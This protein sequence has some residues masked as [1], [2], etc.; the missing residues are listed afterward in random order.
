MKPKEEN[1]DRHAAASI[2]PAA[3]AQ[4]E[5][6]PPE[7][8]PPPLRADV[9]GQLDTVLLQTHELSRGQPS[10][11][12]K[13]LS[14]D[15]PLLHPVI[16]APK[17]I[18][19]QTSHEV[20]LI[21]P[22][23][24][25][26]LSI[27]NALSKTV[28]IQ[29]PTDQ[30]WLMQFGCVN[31]GGQQVC[32]S[33]KEHVVLH[34]S[35]D[36]E[37]NAVPSERELL[38]HIE[39][40]WAAVSAP[41]LRP[42]QSDG[43]AAPMDLDS[44]QR[45]PAAFIDE[46]DSAPIF[47][48]PTG[49]RVDPPPHMRNRPYFK[50]VSETT[51]GK[52]TAGFFPMLEKKLKDYSQPFA[53]I[54]KVQR[55]TCSD[56]IWSKVLSDEFYAHRKHL[57]EHWQQ[58]DHLRLKHK[59]SEAP[60]ALA[61]EYF[62]HPLFLNELQ[63]HR[64]SLAYLASVD[65]D[66]VMRYY[67]YCKDGFQ[68]FNMHIEQMIFPFIHHQL[69]GESLW[70]IIPSSELHKLYQLCGEMYRV[71]YR[72]HPDV[73]DAE[74]LVMGRALLYSKQ[75][76]P[77]LSLLNKHG[78]SYRVLVLSKDDILT[79]DGDCAHFGF[80]TRPGQTIAVASNIATS[81]WLQRGLPFLLD[82]FTWMGDMEK[83]LEQHQA[84]WRK[85]PQ[86]TT[87]S[88]AG[89]HAEPSIHQ[90]KSPHELATN[91]F[92]LCPINFACNFMRGLYADMDALENQAEPVCQYEPKPTPAELGLYKSQCRQI[93]AA[94]HERRDFIKQMDS[95]TCAPCVSRRISTIPHTCMLCLCRGSH[96]EDMLVDER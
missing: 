64:S 25:D 21:R 9:A 40:D 69:E 88:T 6:R 86:Q 37:H 44:L 81:R 53:P 17:V 92:N 58:I 39:R 29:R 38:E 10:N 34:N 79:A 3:V 78:I 87:A 27:Q 89:S 63:L 90:L 49:Q 70:F 55:S 91:S 66:G 19:A 43:Q 13:L 47:D 20:V 50:D 5:S 94:I 32:R 74:C 62:V 77:P 41:T 71:L 42:P 8:D 51:N 26:T 11:F 84:A 68:F 22:C 56:Q 46:A 31:D 80:S 83:I 36:G 1:L 24:H 4:V 67:L 48:P 18:V 76:W 60:P 96:K 95:A 59:Q 85:L 73:S 23:R 14:L 2:S 93:V 16:L 65:F 33:E 54:P 52:Q 75:L 28:G 12:M 82:Y 35:D 30:V 15:A 7:V 72:V 57:R 61:P 45:D